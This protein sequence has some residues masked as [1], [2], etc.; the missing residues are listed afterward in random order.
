MPIEHRRSYLRKIRERYQNGTKKQKSLILNEFCLVCGYSRKYAIRVL[1]GQVEPR[2]KKPGRVAKYSD[3]AFLMHLVE[4]WEWMGR[5]NSKAMRAALPHWL[6]FYKDPAPQMRT[7]LMEVSA[8]T[9]DRLL[10]PYR[11]QRFKAQSS[12]RPSLIK[13]KIPLK[14]WTGRLIILALLKLIPWPTVGS[15]YLANL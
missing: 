13:N 4:L 8:A 12:T 1:R 9:I 14:L 6:R 5:V 11:A 3:G 2:V 10:K 7:L 15:L